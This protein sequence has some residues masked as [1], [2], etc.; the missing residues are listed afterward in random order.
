MLKTT[1]FTGGTNIN[2]FYDT[3][4]R[5]QSI[6]N[7]PASGTSLNYTYTYNNLNQRT[8]TTRED[9]SYWSYNYNDRG[10]LTAGKKFWSDNSAV[11]GSS[12]SSVTTI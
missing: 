1:T 4:G 8:R 5:M 10:E 6:T 3:L 2:R 7:T 9:G 11:A 12:S